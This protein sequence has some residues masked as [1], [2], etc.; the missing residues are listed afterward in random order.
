MNAKFKRSN[1]SINDMSTFTTESIHDEP[2]PKYV[3][4]TDGK[5]IDEEGVLNASVLNHQ[6]STMNSSNNH[7]DK[8]KQTIIAILCLT[9]FPLI[10][11]IGKLIVTF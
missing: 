5:Y 11:L 4:M 7:F 9:C 3:S 6:F 10:Y 8:I 2:N 1:R